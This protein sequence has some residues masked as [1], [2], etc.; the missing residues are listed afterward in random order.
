M[1]NISWGYLAGIVDGEGSIVYTGVHQPIL[2]VANTNYE[3][4]KWLKRKLGGKT[5]FGKLQRSNYQICYLWRL[6]KR[7]EVYIVLNRILPYL[8]IKRE[9]AEKAIDCIL[10]HANPNTRK[11]LGF[12]KERVRRYMKKKKTISPNPDLN[13]CFPS[14]QHT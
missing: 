14:I 2:T 9:A 5:Y 11:K 3:L 10:I 4:I 7:S 6:H 1:E 8:I 12:S 13:I